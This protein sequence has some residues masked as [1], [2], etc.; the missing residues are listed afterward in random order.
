MIFKLVLYMI[1]SSASRV[2]NK[3]PSLFIPFYSILFTT[4]VLAE[5]YFNPDL[6]EVSNYHDID[7]STF[8]NG[9]QAPGK[10]YV[11]IIINGDFVDAKYIDFN[12]SKT[13]H[14]GG[15]QSC[16]TVKDL[17]K[18]GVKIVE[19]DSDKCVLI[20]RLSDASEFFDFN[21]HRLELSIPQVLMEKSVR[22][23]VSPELWDNGI[24]AFLLNYSVGGDSEW[25]TKG[26]LDKEHSLY[27]NLQPGINWGG[28]RFRNYSTVSLNK[29]EQKK[30]TTAYTYAERSIPLW[31][32]KATFGDSSAPSDVFDS[33]SFRGVQIASDDEM[34]PDS[35]Q[36]YAPIIHGVAHTNAKVVIRQNGYIIY[37]SQV[38]PGAFDISDMYSTGG[39]GDFDVII[40]ESDG[41]EQHFTVPY[42]YIPVLQREGR[43]KFDFT[44]GLYRS[45]DSQ[46]V[47]TPIEQL[48][49]IYGLPWGT[50]VFGGTQYSSKYSA[51]SIGLGDNMGEPGAISTSIVKAWSKFSL[52]NK[53]QGNS[54]RI[55][56]NKNFI[57][58]GTDITVAGY[59]YST[60]G[61]YELSDV[62]NSW[63]N[64][65]GS[66][67]HRKNR[68][69]LTMNQSLSDYG[70]LM[71]SAINED[72]W[73]DNSRMHSI[74]ANYNYS[75]R[76]I[77][78]GITYGINYFIDG[79]YSSD[80]S[81]S[82]DRMFSFNMSMPLDFLSK[83]TWSTYSLN[84]SSNGNLSQNIGVSG[85]ALDN[86]ALHWDVQQGFNGGGRTNSSGVNVTYEG[87]RASYSS[88]YHYDENKK[89]I[90]Y[91]MNGG[92]IFHN[93]ELV[94]SPRLGETNVLIKA[95]GAVGVGIT[96]QPLVRTNNHGYALVSDVSPYKKNDIGLDPNTLSEDVELERTN[97]TVIPTRGAIVEADYVAK[98]GYKVLFNIISNKGEHIPFGAN[99]YVDSQSQVSSIVD[100]D[101]KVYFSGLPNSGLINI[102]WGAGIN[103]SCQARFMLPSEGNHHELIKKNI[104]CQ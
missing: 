4:S 48:T 59:K 12:S 13:K 101:N 44:S 66:N 55:R 99:A 71:L 63:V 39:A 17:K 73:N 69:T 60:D 8:E 57:T 50:T 92:A 81:K 85:L 10:Y 74:S 24:N 104:Y 86:N 40:K 91:E 89:S 103:Q 15:L 88:G 33:F 42:A 20:T 37:Q 5:D 29:E 45:L 75:W 72:Y 47:N 38:S 43:L 7:L 93:G 84:N 96:N 23:Y 90:N 25:Y 62:M 64:S 49:G 67:R 19:S 28:W 52:E 79:D 2:I 27:A 76:R 61:F 70:S 80:S 31:K 83:N 82:E 11:D 58:T 56:Y 18:Y 51:I 65:V 26:N 16:L 97:K 87:E 78:F 35:M 9:Q 32:A 77:N 41:S 95:I 100:D 1:T 54:L 68:M 46:V 22:G 3:L 36:G 102:K 30:L 14:G 98:I 21:H 53:A 34:V 6:L 94:L